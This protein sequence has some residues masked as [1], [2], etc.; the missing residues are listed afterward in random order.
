MNSFKENLLKKIELERLAGRVIASIGTGQV[1]PKIDRESMK[2]FLEMSPYKYRNERDLDLYILDEE[3]EAK[4]VL[5]LDNELPIFESS[6]DDV[7]TRRSPRTLEMWRI[8]T[9]RKILNDSDIKESTR[10]DS[11]RMVLADTIAEL[12]LHYTEDDIAELA[13]EGMAWLAGKDA[14]KVGEMLS[15]FGAML[16]YD[17]PPRNFGLDQVISY[18]LTVPQPNGEVAF[19]PLVLYRPADNVLLWIEQT[20]SRADRD[21]METLKSIAA[22]RKSAPVKGDAVFEKLKAEVLQETEQVRT[23]LAGV[24]E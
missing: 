7:V 21:Q 19:G 24:K 8:S 11:V 15:L 18:G 1:P 9:I 16:G 2:L 17:K 12:D 13:K 10:E 22:G 14:A 23:R 5:V 3:G 20:F 6:V 4:K